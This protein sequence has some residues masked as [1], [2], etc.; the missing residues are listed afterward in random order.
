VLNPQIN[1]KSLFSNQLSVGLSPTVS[2]SAPRIGTPSL[3]LLRFWELDVV[4]ERTVPNVVANYYTTD[5]SAT[6][7]AEALKPGN[8]YFA[9]I[10]AIADARTDVS[11]AKPFRFS[12]PDHFSTVMTAIFSP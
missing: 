7:P 2:W 4:N 9:T 6:V 3:Y 1:G 8:V 5:T 11:L 10:S 12:L